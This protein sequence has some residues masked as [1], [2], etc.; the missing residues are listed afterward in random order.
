MF[1]RCIPAGAPHGRPATV[2][3]RSGDEAG[4]ALRPHSVAMVSGVPLD[5][6]E[7]DPDSCAGW[8]PRSRCRRSTRM[9]GFWRPCRGRVRVL[10]NDVDTVGCHRH[11]AAR[12]WLSVT[13]VVL[14]E[15]GC[16]NS[17]ATPGPTCAS[18]C[19]ARESP[20]FRRIPTGAGLRHSRTSDALT[21]AQTSTWSDRELHPD[22]PW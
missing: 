16:F 20:M 5:A 2:C 6:G 12:N 1:G 22:Q 19:R 21:A 8:L 13:M 9:I 3:T 14:D 18:A 7:P 10:A 15:L 4:P 17:E 11:T